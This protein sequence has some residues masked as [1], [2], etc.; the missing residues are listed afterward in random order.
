V[1]GT[2]DIAGISRFSRDIEASKQ[3][4]TGKITGQDVMC[5][6]VPGDGDL[7]SKHSHRPSDEEMGKIGS[8]TPLCR[9]A[10]EIGRE[11]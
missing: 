4:G 5:V 9:S 10:N 2:K 11:A 3:A 8:P 1:I 7:D 6:Y